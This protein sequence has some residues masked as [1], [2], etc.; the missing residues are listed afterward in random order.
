[1]TKK[2]TSAAVNVTGVIGLRGITMFLAAG[3][4]C[5]PNSI[6]SYTAA[7]KKTNIDTIKPAIMNIRAAIRG[8]LNV[9]G[10]VTLRASNIIATEIAAKTAANTIASAPENGT[11]VPDE[12]SLRIICRTALRL[13]LKQTQK[14]IGKRRFRI[15]I[16]LSA[17]V[18]LHH[19]IALYDT[20][21]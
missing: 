5:L 10:R 12:N 11:H 13:L 4:N 18:P 21:A 19:S 17:N 15:N 1:M 3:P 8:C 16:I 6:L 20:I 7:T 14:I 9:I 2:E